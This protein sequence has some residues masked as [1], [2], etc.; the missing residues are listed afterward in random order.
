MKI[1]LYPGCSLTGSSREYRESVL[2]VASALGIS[3]EEVPDWNCC[4]ASAAHNLN[5]ELSLALPTRIL[6]LAEQAGFDKLVIPC[7]ACYSRLTITQH[8]L[9]HNE[10]L[11]VKIVE[12]LE[13]EYKGKMVIQNVIQ[14]IQDDIL[15]KLKESNLATFNHKVA[16]Y[17][18]CLLVRPHGI[19]KFDRPEDPQM[20]DDVMR[21]IGA[22]TIDWAYKNECCGASM[23]IPRN[24]VAGKLSG[25][26]IKDAA[27]RGAEAIIVAC[28]MCHSNLDMRRSN[29][30]KV[31]DESFNQPVLY[32]TQVIGLAIGL[33]PKEL[34]LHRHF[35]PVNLQIKKLEPLKE[36]E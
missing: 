25:N 14:F 6:A 32:I 36:E 30:N 4:G 3:L 27:D 19:L 34:G 5:Q 12:H 28:P 2:A 16:C 35:V 31:M 22:N 23:S 15:N 20:M 33:T 26:I 10:K 9:N 29:I 24:D 8:E 7:A 11:K 1:G 13:M 18:G 21:L 17:Y